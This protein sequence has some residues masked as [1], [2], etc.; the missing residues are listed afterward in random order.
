M[1]LIRTVVLPT[2]II[3]RLDP[4]QAS[5]SVVTLVTKAAGRPLVRTSGEQFADIS[6]VKGMGP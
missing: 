4:Q 2:A 5:R 6:P 3:P 1:P